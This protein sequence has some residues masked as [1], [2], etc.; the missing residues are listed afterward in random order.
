MVGDC[1]RGFY[2]GLMA[3]L[4]S[5]IGAIAV[6]G[7]G[8]QGRALALNWRDS[9]RNVIVGLPP[10]S[11]SRRRA[12]LDEISEVATPGETAGSADIICFAFPDYLHGRVWRDEL[13]N[14][15]RAGSTLLFLHG[16]SIHFGQI[17]PPRDCDVVLMAP[18]APG[19][20][21]REK[22]LSDR[23]VSA[24]YAVHQDVSGEAETE[25][26]QLAA[27]AGFREDRLIETT[28][29]HE[30]IGDLFGEQ[31]VLCGGL[32]MLIKSGFDTLVDKGL[33]PDNAWLEVAYQLD[34]IVNLIKRHGIQGMF[35][36]I[37]VAAQFGSLRAGPEIIDDAV[38]KSMVDVYRRIAS[39]EFAD[40][41]A[42]LDPSDLE[43]LRHN[44]AGLT[45]PALEE[46]ARKFNR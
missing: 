15:V 2:I 8:S 7:Y 3:D 1:Q 38:R 12:E 33:P 4:R 6:L 28:F 30:A 36:R 18:H 45:T 14:R 17:E 5:D 9:G 10:Q 21:V 43:K 44:L 25:I 26:L 31:A 40:E 11:E 24:F 46:S 32:A 34:L 37:S 16:L 39:G 35:E 41:L 13:E 42:A 29:E 23:S 22:Y 27:D 19:V 20:S